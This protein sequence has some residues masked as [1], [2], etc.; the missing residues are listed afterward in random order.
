MVPLAQ[1]AL[2]CFIKS[3][4]P[5]PYLWARLDTFELVMRFVMASAMVC[6]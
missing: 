1:C 2:C 6:M 3:R 4:R 5:G